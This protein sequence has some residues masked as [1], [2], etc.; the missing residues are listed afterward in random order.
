MNEQ[1]R[2]FQRRV[3][4]IDRAHTNRTRGAFSIRADGLVIPTSRRKLRFAFPWRALISGFLVMVFLK[5]FLIW[6]L[7]EEAYVARTEAML[8][9]SRNEQLAARVLMPDGASVFM[10]ARFED[11]VAFATQP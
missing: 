1:F 9:G 6:Y 7:G 8:S 11:L 10:A 5:G 4:R 2:L 3:S